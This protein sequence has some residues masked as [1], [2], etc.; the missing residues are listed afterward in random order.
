MGL[1][2]EILTS[3]IGDAKAERLI[4]KLSGVR[5]DV[6]SLSLWRSLYNDGDRLSAEGCFNV[7]LMKSCG[8]DGALLCPF[9]R[10]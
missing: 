7:K 6:T 2:H 8:R 1:I 10:C 9:R 5:S 4:E 3:F